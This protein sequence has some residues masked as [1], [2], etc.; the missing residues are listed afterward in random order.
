MPAR[1]AARRSVQPSPS[2]SSRGI[3]FYTCVPLRVRGEDL[4]ALCIGRRSAERPAARERRL[5]ELLAEQL[6]VAIGNARILEEL[7]RTKEMLEESL[8]QLKLQTED[9]ETLVYHISHDVRAPLVSI[10]GFVEI[11][12]KEFR[13]GL[14][15]NILLYR[16]RIVSN[17]R[18]V[19]RLVHYLIGLAEIGK[20]KVS[21]SEVLLSEL[22]DES[23]RKLEPELAEKNG[24]MVW[25]CDVTLRAER[26]HLRRA[27]EHVLENSIHYA[28]PGVP[29]RIEVGCRSEGDY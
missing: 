10:L 2:K 9:F 6:A 12:E 4:G 13:P 14:P 26:K 11:L 29:L 28:R 3:R 20:E 16:G 23:K 17:V 24:K 25:D 8:H 27:L 5:L 19:E 1:L 21:P 18:R 15:Q 7:R 22:L